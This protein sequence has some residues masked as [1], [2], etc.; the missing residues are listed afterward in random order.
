[1]TPN[2]Y[3]EFS[4]STAIYPKER[5]MEYLTC[6]LASEV[7]EYLGKWKKIIRDRNGEVDTMEAYKLALEA[8]DIL[9]YVAR[10]CDE[11]EWDLQDVIDLNVEK[12]TERKEKN[13]LQGSGDYR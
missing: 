13:T 4:R 9:W 2:E 1:M 7:G 5:A 11:Q 12:L 10:I 6:G 8:G 3:Q